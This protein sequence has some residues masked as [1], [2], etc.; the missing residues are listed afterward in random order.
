GGCKAYATQ[1][2]AQQAAPEP[3]PAGVNDPAYRN[4]CGVH[5][6][7]NTLVG[8]TGTFNSSG[9]RSGASKG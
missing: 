7:L 1:G 8:R 5:G 9:R 3:V 6:D 2:N 4:S